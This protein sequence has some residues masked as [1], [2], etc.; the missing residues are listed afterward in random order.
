MG[1]DSAVLGQ[2]RFCKAARKVLVNKMRNIENNGFV[3]SLF[4]F[5]QTSLR[6]C[7]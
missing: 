1:G 2:F 6:L 3:N 5:P 4:F 7:T